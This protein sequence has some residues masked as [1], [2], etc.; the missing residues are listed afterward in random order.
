[1]AVNGG[2]EHLNHDWDLPLNRRVDAGI[3]EIR[4]A[5]PATSRAGPRSR[6]A[7]AALTRKAP[8]QR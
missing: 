5:A 4:E 6:C 8:C 3:G 7:A 2:T 1:M